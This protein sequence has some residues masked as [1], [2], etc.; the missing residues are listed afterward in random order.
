[1]IAVR[2][3][4]NEGTGK[5]AADLSALLPFYGPLMSVDLMA[6]RDGGW[7]VFGA[8][9]RERIEAAAARLR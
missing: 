6:G 4:A 7:L 1:V 8:V 2:T 3:P 9:P 5:E